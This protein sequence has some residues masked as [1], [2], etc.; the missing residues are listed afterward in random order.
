MS[1]LKH[2]TTIQAIAK[3]T[4]Q[5]LSVLRDLSVQFRALY[6]IGHDAHH[7]TKGTTFY[8]DHAEFGVL[9]PIYED[10]YDGLVERIKGL[11]GAVDLRLVKQQ[12]VNVAN[13]HET[14]GMTADDYF[15][16]LLFLEKRVCGEIDIA[17]K[18]PTMDEGV[19]NLLCGII[20]D[21]QK[22]RQYKMQQRLGGVEKSMTTISKA[23][24][25]GEAKTVTFGKSFT[26]LNDF[27]AHIGKAGKGWFHGNQ[28]VPGSKSVRADK[29]A[30]LMKQ[31]KEAYKGGSTIQAK[32]AEME[33]MEHWKKMADG[34]RSHAMQM[35]NDSAAEDIGKSRD[36][37]FEFGH[38]RTAKK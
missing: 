4:D 37:G 12:A 38:G 36:R 29:Y 10:I 21:S 23:G 26:Q 31:S 5:T 17:V 8:Q 7:E 13:T 6:L 28:V 14:E 20:D 16:V 22:D 15:N 35:L 24:N 32:T 18:E 3:A 27:R 30:S 25:E 1:I 33:A 34:E 9:Y 2:L 11:G 19:R